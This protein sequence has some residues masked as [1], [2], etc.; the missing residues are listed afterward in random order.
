[1]KRQKE[2]EGGGGGGG[3][4]ETDIFG[5]PLRAY[6]RGEDPHRRRPPEAVTCAHPFDIYLYISIYEY[7]NIFRAFVGVGRRAMCYP[8]SSSLDGADREEQ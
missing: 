3:G 7:I 4:R 2:E 1:M 5:R 6:G 8:R